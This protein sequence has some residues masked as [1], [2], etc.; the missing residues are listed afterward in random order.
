MENGPFTVRAQFDAVVSSVPVKLVM[1]TLA[2]VVA[3]ARVVVPVGFALKIALFEAIGVQAHAAPP[4]PVTAVGAVVPRIART[5]N[6]SSPADAG[7]IEMFGFVL[8]PLAVV[9]PAVG[10]VAQTPPMRTVAHTCF[11]VPLTS[12]AVIV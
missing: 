12:V 5:A 6:A 3:A 10:V 1:S 9:P 8:V 2:M 7:E 4:V 11:A